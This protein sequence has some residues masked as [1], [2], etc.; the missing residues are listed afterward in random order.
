MSKTERLSLSEPVPCKADTEAF[1]A[2]DGLG[3]VVLTNRMGASPE[4]SVDK[5]ASVY[6]PGFAVGK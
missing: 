3:T 5:I 2:D 6:M 4:K 1:S